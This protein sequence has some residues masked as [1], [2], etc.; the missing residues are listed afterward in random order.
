MCSVQV[1][2]ENLVPVARPIRTRLSLKEDFVFCRPAD[3]G[4]LDVR[5][6]AADAENNGER[7]SPSPSSSL[8]H[9]HSAHS[10]LAEFRRRNTPTSNDMQR[11]A[12]RDNAEA[13]RGVSTGDM[14][15]AVCCRF[16]V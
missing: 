9:A 3:E 16:C 14:T 13:L 10:L 15:S 5:S 7:L 6:L 2:N 12:A 11:L 4:P 1:S 8:I